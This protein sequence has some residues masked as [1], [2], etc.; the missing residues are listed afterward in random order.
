MPTYDPTKGVIT[1]GPSTII[2]F[3]KDT[4][5]KAARDEDAFTKQV[6]ADGKAARSK[7]ANKGGSIEITLK[8]DSPSNDVLMAQ[9]ALDELTGA[10]Q[11][12]FLYKDLTGTTRVSAP[13]AW[14][15][16]IADVEKAK[17]L[18]EF[19]WI[20]D[21]EELDLSPGGIVAP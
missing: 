7:N 9:A 2:G 8:G 20:I 5:L 14:I 4:F 3:G 18:G 1:V 11:V 15:K 12:P 6:G 21:C 17:E 13:K 16:K 10:G 19:V